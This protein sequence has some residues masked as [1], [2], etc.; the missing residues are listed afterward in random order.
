MRFGNKTFEKM[1]FGAWQLG[2]SEFFDAMSMEEG[3]ELVN[4]SVELGVWF[5]D[6][7]PGYA[8]GKSESIL[9]IALKNVRDQVFIN[10]K[11]GHRADG[12]SNFDERTMESAVHESLERLQTSYLDSLILHNPSM[13]ILQGKTKHFQEMKR[14]KEIGLIHHY[15]ASIDT[16]DELNAVLNHTDCDVIELLFNVYAQASIPLFEEIKKRNILL[17]IKVPLD[18]G[19]LTGKYNEFTAFKGIKSRW[20]AEDIVRR[21]NLTKRLKTMVNDD[22]LTKYALGFILSYDAVG[23]IIPGTRTL[24][25]LNSNLEALKYKLPNDLKTK[26]I[27]FYNSEIKNNPLPW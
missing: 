24:E 5:F 16:Y 9:G 2:N 6:T 20:T 17:I 10:S 27:D 19:W 1:G 11:F 18:S 12:S 8:S 25:Q 23:V 14:L 26:M 22:N 21:S 4:K 15:G 13:D 3:I 7:A